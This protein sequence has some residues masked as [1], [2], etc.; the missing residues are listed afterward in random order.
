MHTQVR[1]RVHIHTRLEGGSI[2]I[3]IHSPS[4]T[5]S[6]VDLET[7]GPTLVPSVVPSR[8]KT[9]SQVSFGTMGFGPIRIWELEWVL[10]L[11]GFRTYTTCQ[12]GCDLD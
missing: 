4:K 11:S 8:L 2:T 10:V 5:L 6:K 9:W 3:S 12:N 1:G 7:L